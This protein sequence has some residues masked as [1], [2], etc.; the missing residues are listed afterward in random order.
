M[1]KVITLL[2][3][4]SLSILCLFTLTSCEKSTKALFKVI[5]VKLTDE[6]YAI[7]IGKGKTELKNQ[8][9]EALTQIDIDAIIQKYQDMDSVT[10][11]YTIPNS[12][13]GVENP[14]I[15]ATNAEFAPFEYKVG[16]QYFGID[17]EIA[18]QLAEKLGKTLV[19][20]NMNFDAIITSVAGVEMEEGVDNEGYDTYTHC[21]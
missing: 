3:S 18:V 14:L 5:D 20:S 9:N 15:V 19:L 17:I 12:A 10:T 7:A 8:I 11:G 4:V 1:K 6:N 13:Y 16:T 21:D 2:L